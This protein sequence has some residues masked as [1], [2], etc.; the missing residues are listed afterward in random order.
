MTPKTER[1]RVVGEVP[2]PICVHCGKA[3]GRR[4]CT[5]QTAYACEDDPVP[6]PVS[7]QHVIS[8]LV[9]PYGVDRTSGRP[10]YRYRWELWDGRSWHGGERPF[11]TLRCATDFARKAYEAGFRAAV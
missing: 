9:I 7:N 8:Y 1:P 11:C 5:E 3:Y 4:T 2:R 10:R 6:Q